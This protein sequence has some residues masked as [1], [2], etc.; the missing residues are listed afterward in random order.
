[1]KYQIGDL[2]KYRDDILIITGVVSYKG[3]PTYAEFY[4]TYT[5]ITTTIHHLK[6]GK[7]TENFL[8]LM[9]EKVG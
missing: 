2:V 3:D 5:N 9:S 6:R 4:Y 8:D 7:Y 1:M